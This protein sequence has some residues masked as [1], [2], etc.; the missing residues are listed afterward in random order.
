[1]NLERMQHVLQDANLNGWLFYD[2]RKSNPIA[3]AVLQLPTEAM[4]TRRW[5][6]YVPAQGTPT[7]IISAVE[8]HV[9]NSLPGRRLL[10]STWQEMHTHLQATVPAHARVAMEYSP[11]NAI[12][13][14]ARVDAGTLELVRAFNIE[15][16]TS[17]DLAQRFIAQLTEAQIQSQRQA[18]S[19]LIAAKNTLFA[20]LHA[21]LEAGHELNEYE[22]Q[23]RFVALIEQAGMILPEDEF[24]IVAVNDNASN[25]HYEPTATMHRSLRRGDLVLFD[26]WARLP[27]PDA[28]WGDLTWMAFVGT[29]D[30]IP[31]RQR[32]V[33][34]TVR[35]ARDSAIAFVRER[36]AA[37]SP[38]RGC[39]V[40]DVARNIVTKAGYGAYFVHRTGHSIGTELHGSSANIDNFET[41]DER[42]LLPF[43]CNSIEPG[44]Y[45]PEFGVRSEVDLLVFAHDAE[46]SGG[47]VQQEIVPLL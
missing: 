21:D 25:P 5:F 31:A 7:A 45:L 36:L 19:L 16:V 37:G 23:Q 34:E 40:D 14:V 28:I 13:Y 39:D 6:Y 12:P 9:L 35:C 15:V 43:T 18:S 32:E 47:P 10:F 38:V 46:V 41:R 44:I 1:M 17:A 20:Q 29:C 11:L 42:T 33:F 4:Y 30:E 27:R 8:P 3:Y 22:V 26:F 24:P 2:F